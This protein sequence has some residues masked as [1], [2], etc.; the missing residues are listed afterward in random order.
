MTAGNDRSPVDKE[1]VESLWSE[2]RDL[3]RRLEGTSVQRMAIEIGDLKLEI[4]R[5]IPGFGAPSAPAGSGPAPPSGPVAPGGLTGPGIAP[6]ARGASG[7]FAAIG[8]EQDRRIPVLSPLVGTFFRAAQPGS[9]PF[10]EQGDS[11]DS[12]KTLC[13]VEAMKLMNE[14][15]SQEP[16]TVVEI[17]AE[18]GDWVEFE[19]VLMYL[20]PADDE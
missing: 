1:A 16:G 11:V 10:V 15:V 20:E 2:A 17:L 18:N 4:E 19:Q 14:V 13:I 3:I 9:K 6:E 12:G 5:A 7:V 8:G